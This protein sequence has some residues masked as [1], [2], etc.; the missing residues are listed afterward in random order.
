MIWLAIHHL[1]DRWSEQKLDT[2][3][4]SIFD[5]AVSFYKGILFSGEKNGICV[6]IGYDIIEFSFGSHIRCFQV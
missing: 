1:I 6:L 3:R 4:H 2:C 5:Y